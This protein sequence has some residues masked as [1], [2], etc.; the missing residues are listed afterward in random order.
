MS[1]TIL[2]DYDEE[3]RKV[4]SCFEAPSPADLNKEATARKD[5]RDTLHI[6]IRGQKRNSCPGW[7]A[8]SELLNM[9]LDPLYFAVRDSTPHGRQHGQWEVDSFERHVVEDSGAGEVCRRRQWSSTI[10]GTSVD[11]GD[12]GQGNRKSGAKELRLIHMFCMWWKAFFSAI[13]RR[14]LRNSSFNWNDAFHGYITGRRREGAM[15]TQRAVS[16]RL[17][18]EC[19]QQLT[20]FKDM[21]NAFTCTSAEIRA[22]VLEELIN[23]TDRPMFFERAQLHCA[24]RLG[25]GALLWNTAVWQLQGFERGPNFLSG[26]ACDAAHSLE[27]QHGGAGT[28]GSTAAAGSYTCG[29]HM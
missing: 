14:N 5:L 11:R 23:E 12:T 8:P 26:C 25:G 19:I 4:L 6:F 15:I 29:T 20:D 28:G 27:S 10:F 13:L 1:A 9:A 16:M 17:R 22:E 2:N 3:V 21:S 18:K 7:S 24:V